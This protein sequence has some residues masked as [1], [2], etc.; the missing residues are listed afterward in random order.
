MNSDIGERSILLRCMVCQDHYV[1]PIYIPYIKRSA[2]PGNYFETGPSILQARGLPTLSA[3]LLSSN[4]TAHDLLAS[5]NL[6]NSID[7]QSGEY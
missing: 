1:G 6:E 2:T 7:N 5:N 3:D 4:M